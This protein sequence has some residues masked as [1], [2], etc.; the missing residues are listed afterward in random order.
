MAEK[1]LNDDDTNNSE[2][3]LEGYAR[4]TMEIAHCV[5]APHFSQDELFALYGQCSRLH[6]HC[7][8][9]FANICIDQATWQLFKQEFK[10]CNNLTKYLLDTYVVN[11][12]DHLNLVDATACPTMANVMVT[13]ENGL[14]VIATLVKQGLLAMKINPYSLTSLQL[15]ETQTGSVFWEP[16]KED[17]DLLHA[18]DYQ[19]ITYNPQITPLLARPVFTIIKRLLL[20]GLSFES[21]QT[22][23][24][25]K[26]HKERGIQICRD[27]TQ[28]IGAQNFWELFL[29]GPLDAKRGMVANLSQVKKMMLAAFNDKRKIILEELSFLFRKP[30]PLHG[31]YDL[32]A[33]VA[34]IC[35]R[36]H[37]IPTLTS[38]CKEFEIE[39]T[40]LFALRWTIE[41]NSRDEEQEGLDHR[42]V[43][44]RSILVKF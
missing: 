33:D 11:K 26:L 15:F 41:E 31:A 2:L 13:T 8:V 3:V 39:A 17:I 23:L 6:G 10:T 24:Y 40:C 43:R 16:S 44:H 14:Y 29:C 27:S 32:W 4:V 22:S 34:T 18:D 42:N 25:D 36:E 30:N 21:P 35:L 1:T 12:F 7:W 20:P 38:K 28:F 5:R 37:I 9:L 19:R